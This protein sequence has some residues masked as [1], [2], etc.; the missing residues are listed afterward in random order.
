MAQT[1]KL[2]RS[3]VGGNRPTTAQ[4]DLGELAIN[5]T[6]GKIY[7]EK[8]GSN[9]ESIQEIFVTNAQNSGSL[10]TI[11]N[12]VITGSILTSGSTNLIG[13]ETITGSLYVNNTISGSI[14]GIGNVT[15]YSTS[16]DSRLSNLQT[17]SES[18]DINI[19][20]INS[21][22]AS[23]NTKNSTLATYT[24]S[25]DTKFSTLG[26]YTASVDTKFNTL[27]SYTASIDTKFSTLGSYTAS[28]D[29]KWN[30]L[31]NVTSSL[32]SK[33]GS[34][35]TTGSNTFRGNQTINGNVVISGSLTAQEYIL[36]SSV[37]NMIV[38]YAS[39]STAFGNTIDDTHTFTGSVNITGS[40]NISGSSTIK[41][42][43]RFDSTIDPGSQNISSSFLFTSASNTSQGFDLYYRQ[44]NNLVKL[45][46][47]EGG[48]S[49]GLLYGG[50]VSYSGTT[51][52]VSKGSAIVNSLNA[53]TGS[54]GSS[55]FIYVEWPNYSQIATYL[56][57][58]QNT[59]IYVDDSGTIHQQPT[60]FTTNQYAQA[61]PL[62]RITHATIQR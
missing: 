45:K 17:K 43:L 11:G 42:S 25:I 13:D 55:N 44:N 21:F 27:G 6:D 31:E 24:G 9:G 23:E 19:S 5:T 48:I 8:S 56:T 18:V 28:I 52:N 34:Y 26:T 15:S 4:L 36:S 22:T 62:G 32:I 57:S 59:Y 20:N 46:W 53:N 16:V 38:E 40:L 47:L 41:G 39:G 49:T 61:I 33:T 35:A 12:L 14:S 58:S 3:A 60:Y 10:N 54:Q 30:T 50:I 1:I 2:R 37:T 51:I 29:S 7:F